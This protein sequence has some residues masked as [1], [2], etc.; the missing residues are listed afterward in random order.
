MTDDKVASIAVFRGGREAWRFP[1]A[2]QAIA[3]SHDGAKLAIIHGTTVSLTDTHG[4][5]RWRFSQWLA[6]AVAFTPDDRH[7]LVQAIGGLILLDAATGHPVARA[8]GWRFG[9]RDELPAVPP[10]TAP[11]CGD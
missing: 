10:G 7:V 2:P 8:C 1:E 5:V 6:Q 3:A 4:A 9:L 11:V